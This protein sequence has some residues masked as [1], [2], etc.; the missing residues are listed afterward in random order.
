MNSY[1]LRIK[2]LL[3]ILSI[4]WL[5]VAS[6]QESKK[7]N[8]LQL[9]LDGISHHTVNSIF[10]DDKGFIWLGTINGLNR[11][12]GINYKIFLADDDTG[13]GLSSNYINS[14]NQDKHGN[15]WVGTKYGVNVLMKEGNYFKTYLNDNGNPNTISNANIE[16]IFRDSKDR[17]WIGS[18]GG[19]SLYREDSNDFINFAHDPQNKYSISGNVVTAIM[20]DRKGRLWVGTAYSGLNLLDV[21]T[22]K[23]QRF[24]KE[25]TKK[26]CISGNSISAIYEDEKGQ[27]WVGAER[28]GLNKFEEASQTF[29]WYFNEGKTHSIASN[30]VYSIIEDE[31]GDLMV[32]GMNGG[33]SVYNGATDN[34]YRYDTHG[35]YNPFGSKA[36]VFCHYKLKTGEVIIATSN[37]GVKIQD[38]YPTAIE[39]HQ[40]ARGNKQSLPMNNVAAICEDADGNFWIGTSGGGLSRLETETGNFQAF[41][42]FNDKTI[43]ALSVDNNDGLWIGTLENGLA[44]Y[45]K[46]SGKFEYYRHQAQNP[47]T[48]HTDNVK[49]LK[50]DHLGLWVGTDAGVSLFDPAEKVFK[51]YP[52]AISGREKR[53]IGQVNGLLLDHTQQLWVASENGLHFFDKKQE[54]FTQHQYPAAEKANKPAWV[55]YFYEDRQHHMWVSHL[56]GDLSWLNE[57]RQPCHFTITSDNHIITEVTNIIE[58]RQGALWI[59]CRQGLFK[60]HVDYKAYTIRILNSFNKN[61]GLQGEVFNINAGVLSKHNGTI[62]LGGL[63][64]LNVFNPKKMNL[65]PN[66]P[67]VVLTEIRLNGRKFDAGGKQDLSELQEI[68]FSEKDI[69]TID[70]HFAALNYIKSK[71]NQYA[72]LLEGHDDRW[73]YGGNKGLISYANLSPGNYRLNVKAAN[74][75]GI[76]NNQGSRLVI[77]IKPVMWNTTGFRLILLAFGLFATV[78]GFMV[79]K[80]NISKWARPKSLGELPFRN[81][82]PKEENILSK[83]FHDKAFMEKAIAYVESNISD[84]NLSIDNMCSELGLSRSRL[85]RKIKALTNHTVSNF[86]K[87]IRLKKAKTY[88]DSNPRSVGEVAFM[89]G[90]KSH[91]HFT[92]SFKE[93]FGISPSE[94]AQQQK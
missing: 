46:A 23:F 63:D 53:E 80:R 68:S 16:I 73:H 21:A 44:R 66:I 31:Q 33:I 24:Q 2:L 88:L 6:G 56:K 3:T 54:A 79:Y 67:P 34:F 45:H 14:I 39:L 11:Y 83:E 92:R 18:W 61:D 71:K 72:Y 85:F 40:N 62:L 89:I 49:N 37:G 87:D 4:S 65:N 22:R 29:K 8:F 28:G 36:S 59:T 43:H 86:I 47:T 13:S 57:K 10:Q 94:Y 75:D 52:Y 48:I 93:K 58:D 30:T 41:P 38:N 69:S 78:L 91:A 15:I 5:G 50:V 25:A 19:L 64:G 70:M 90:F 20:E 76:W 60:C 51:H 32:G 42:T 26:N 1:T 74:N 27:I 35:N 55:S 82:K 9:P 77:N 12:D 84:E 81:Y 7:L 17:M